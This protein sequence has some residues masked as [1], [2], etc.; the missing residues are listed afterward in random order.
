M[1]LCHVTGSAFRV[2]MYI[3]ELL[4]LVAYSVQLLETEGSLIHYLSF[5]GQYEKFA[6]EGELLFELNPVS[7][8]NSTF[9]LSSELC[10]ICWVTC[11]IPSCARIFLVLCT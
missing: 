3:L 4:G 1:K 11:P 10:G 7:G 2:Y 5:L 8:H 9:K 6:R